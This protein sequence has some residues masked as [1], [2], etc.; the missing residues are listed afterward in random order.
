MPR[1]GISFPTL[2]F[3]SFLL[4]LFESCRWTL[5]FWVGL[6]KWGKPPPLACPNLWEEEADG[7]F[8]LTFLEESLP[9]PSQASSS[10]KVPFSFSPG[11]VE[12][13]DGYVVSLFPAQSQQTGIVCHPWKVLQR[14]KTVGELLC[15]LP[16]LF[17]SVPYLQTRLF[18]GDCFQRRD[19]WS[20]AKRVLCVSNKQ[21]AC[22][23]SSRKSQRQGAMPSWLRLQRSI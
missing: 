2:F 23:S 17:A 21:L 12:N 18:L 15:P 9:K 20:W 22:F 5:V 16:C 8:S 6:L 1:M 19:S 7:F 14:I 11:I 3:C 4:E 13:R 10:S